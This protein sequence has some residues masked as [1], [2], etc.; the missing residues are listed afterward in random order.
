MPV[1]ESEYSFSLNHT[2]IVPSHFEPDCDLAHMLLCRDYSLQW[3]V[4][5]CGEPQEMHMRN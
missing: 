3:G 1:A 5:S 4:F 2:S